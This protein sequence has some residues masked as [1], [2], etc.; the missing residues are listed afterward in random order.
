MTKKDNPAGSN[1]KVL[2]RLLLGFLFLVL[3]YIFLGEYKV[4]YV[5]IHNTDAAKLNL[6]NPNGDL[7]I[8]AFSSVFIGFVLGYWF[9]SKR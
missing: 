3:I 8:A 4:L 6:Y 5:N 7:L 9:K 1:H 2:K